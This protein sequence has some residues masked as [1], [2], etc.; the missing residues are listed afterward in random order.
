VTILA[1]FLP[2][3]VLAAGNPYGPNVNASNTS[4]VTLT[5]GIASVDD[6][7]TTG[8]SVSI[9][10]L[11]GI[12]KVSVTTQTLNAPSSA[13]QNY[14]TSGGALY[15]DVSIKLPPG[16]TAPPGATSTVSFTSSIVSSDSK[17]NYWNGVAWVSVNNLSVSG[18]TIS[19]DVPVSALTGTNFV[20]AA[21]LSWIYSS[22]PLYVLVGAVVAVG[23]VVVS[24][25][26][27]SKRKER[28]L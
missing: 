4:S 6:S 15:F 2:L 19:G 21:P 17:L 11:A 22:T 24:W 12:P 16:T 8:V 5:Q 26:I 14:S 7:S 20:I 23:I 3:S 9:S 28:G 13:V 1:L 27:W 25:S 10:G 18:N